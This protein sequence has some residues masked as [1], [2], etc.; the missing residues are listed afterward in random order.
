MNLTRVSK[1][2]APT[3]LMAASLLSTASLHG[4]LPA[5]S[6]TGR[7]VTQAVDASDRV[8][9][10][11]KARPWI[12]QSA[13]LGEIPG[14]TSASHML[15]LLQRGPQQQQALSEYL[16][17]LQNPSS[18]NFHHWLTPGQFADAFGVN[19]EDLQAV[20]GWLQSEGFTIDKVSK[21][22]NLVE[23]SGNAGQ[24][25]QAFQSHIHRFSV[26]GKVEA[27]SITGVQ[28]PR[29][30][31]PV[32]AGLVNLDSAHA[33][34]LVRPG[35]KGR[36]DP[37]THRIKTEI[38]PELTILGGGAPSLYVDPSDAAVIY[39]TPNKT[40]NP[41]YTGTTLDGSG[42]TLGVVGVSNV[43][44]TA[45]SLYRQAFLGETSSTVN[46]PTVVV[47]GNDPGLN[48]AE[49][50]SWLDLELLGG[51]A[52]KAKI[53]YYASNETDLADGLDTAIVRA[54]EDNAISILS[55]SYGACESDLGTSGNAFFSEVYQQ[56]AAQGI[57]V[58]VSSGDS[59]SASCDP[60]SGAT[61]V[62]GLTVSGLAST[63]YN[64]AVGGTDFDVLESNFA[65]YVDDQSSGEPPYYLTAIKY[66]PEEPWNDSTVVN[67][68][69]ASNKALEPGGVTNI[70]AG[71]GGVSAV[72]TK[73]AY[74][75]ALTP[76]DGTRD[77]PDVSFLAANGLYGA[78]WVL[79]E[80]S[81]QG[82]DCETA[83]GQLTSNSTVHGA[84]GTSA[85]TPAFA[86]MLALVEQS[87]GS[88]LGQ[89]N[90]ILYRLAGNKYSTVF[91]DTT[92]G[93]NS[94]VCSGG[95][96]DC[97][98]NGFLTGYDAKTGYDLATGLGSVDA[99]AMVKNWTTAATTG[100]STTLSINN[101]TTPI[102]VTHGA[103]LDLKVGVNPGTA[104]GT[105]ALVANT[106]NLGGQLAIPIVDG[107]GTASYNGLPGGDYSVYAR[108][109]G[110]GSDA[111]SSSSPISVS[112]APEASTTGVIINAYDPA[113]GIPLPATSS[114]P[115]G[116]LIF[117][118]AAIYG[119]AEGQA[120]SQG[121]ATGSITYSDNGK[122]LGTQAI[123][124]FGT[125]SFPNYAAGFYFFP[126]GTHSIVA[127]FP[128]D[129]SYKASTSS[130]AAFTVAKGQTQVQV[131]ANPAST[132]SVRNDTI[133]AIINTVSGGDGPTGTV[134][135]QSN[136]VT[137]GTTTNIVS[138]NNPTTGY[139]EGVA[140]FSVAGS[141]L[142]PGTNPLAVNYTGDNNYVGG[143]AT[144]I[145][146][147]SVATFSLSTS[148]INVA[149]GS[150]S[151]N[152][153][154]ISATPLNDFTGKVNLTCAVT[155]TPANA[156]SPVTCT[157]PASINLTGLN[158]VTGTLT[159]N[160]T[161][162]TAAGIYVITVTGTDAATGKIKVSTNSTVTVTGN[163]ANP[164]IAL[165]NG[166]NI[167]IAP[168]AAS[169]N[170]STVTVTPSGGFTGSVALACTVASPSG[171]TD[172][173]SCSLSTGT[174]NL[175]GTSAATST[176]T[177][178]STA[179]AAAALKSGFG[180]LGAI[181]AALLLLLPARRRLA[182]LACVI[183]FVS[184]AGILSGCGGSSHTT[185]P[186][187]PGTS[188][189]TYVVTITGTASGVTVA[190]TTVN[191]TVN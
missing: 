50:E 175:S 168:G 33:H 101:A 103:T 25:Q 76:A 171:A 184:L 190:K 128:G 110:D 155:T 78:S 27:T 125:A 26:R 178:A 71:G 157:V 104:T 108:Y 45:V 57:T 28:V 69:V 96:P 134:T 181:I 38:K 163:A 10:L 105:A 117:A 152:T 63:P 133:T 1:I 145:V 41:N 30:L 65:T 74:Q 17:D 61:A 186:T 3:L 66:I 147:V 59:G 160:T 136:G 51:L 53:I 12:K 131:S 77:L 47:D 32:I 107:T 73:P 164:A 188:P 54:V 161:S 44:L 177:V 116:S 166:G 93:D 172:P 19:A 158:A 106:P 149:A 34:P 48:D 42:L 14:N 176:L 123:S 148:A 130:A 126:G 72:Y 87:T 13:D 92:L 150:A 52:P 90:T 139:T 70:I 114:I 2:F 23:F 135:L 85:S 120:D 36:Y 7:R 121:Q 124:S 82:N 40:L 81:A 21:A 180:L 20:T 156:I 118:E 91:H 142:Q 4:Q 58:A 141:A 89:A 179:A 88:R 31:A 99:A 35:S 24:L 115:Y 55:I 143:T 191:V 162:S 111:A 174:V 132:T 29:A 102:S 187:N 37:S 64:I 154:L 100:T 137:L 75:S 119:T 98:G 112:I 173:L 189:G 86:G 159:A 167:T 84:G 39:D 183:A 146:T 6:S 60:D 79:C 43:D 18:A 16:G 15:L 138:Q 170:T 68:S 67:T 109:G 182:P 49:I 144:G 151:G 5:I 97:G 80:V 122:K 140:T 62:N 169:G 9:L 83:N 11:S 8:S 129:E 153:A 185:T 95:S 22:R 56:A 127:S 165:S 46:L 94:V 113:T